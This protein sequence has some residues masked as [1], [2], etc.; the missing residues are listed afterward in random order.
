MA[1]RAEIRGV[2]TGFG[3]IAGVIV[4]LTQ[5]DLGLPGQVILQSLQ[6]HIAASLVGLAIFLA[7][8]GARW[9][10]GF[11]AALAVFAGGH[12]MWRVADQYEGRSALQDSERLAEFRVLS[13]NVLESNDRHAE[14][15]DFIAGS[16]ADIVVIMEAA[17]MRQHLPKLETVYPYRAGCVSAAT[18][19]LM[20]LSKLALSD[21]ELRSLGTT[22]PNRMIVARTEIAEEPVTLVAAHLTKPYFDGAGLHEVWRLTEHLSEIDGP[23]VLAGDFNSAPWSDAIDMLIQRADLLPP[24]RYNATWPTEFGPLGVPIDHIFSRAPIVIEDIEALAD[25][26]GSNHLGLFA[27]LQLVAQ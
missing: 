14:I 11:I 26:M 23:L 16:G 2:L 24:P 25:P 9:R 18:C 8:A 6:L 3:L 17:R 15:A 7:L 12:V 27:R 5:V 21:T 10:A 13:F 19:D 22:Y 1:I 20:M 4:A